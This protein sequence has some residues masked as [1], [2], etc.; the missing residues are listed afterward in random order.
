MKEVLIICL[1]FLAPWQRLAQ[2][3]QR[4]RVGSSEEEGEGEREERGA[5]EKDEV[6]L[7]GGSLQGSQQPGESAKSSHGSKESGHRQQEVTR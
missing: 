1:L 5:P 3:A 6:I 2:S 4:I 7:L